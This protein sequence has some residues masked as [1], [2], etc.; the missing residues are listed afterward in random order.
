[1]AVGLAEPAIGSLVGERDRRWLLRGLREA[2]RHQNS[3][4]EV[5]ANASGSSKRLALAV[6]AFLRALWLA[7]HM[8]R[9]GVL[10]PS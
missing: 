8:W 5:M 10:V 4:N 7:F 9:P 2:V 6:R 3:W 1:M